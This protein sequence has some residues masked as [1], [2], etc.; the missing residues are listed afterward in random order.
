MVLGDLISVVTNTPSH[1]RK[2]EASHLWVHKDGTPVKELPK[3]RAT[4]YVGVTVTALDRL[5]IDY[6]YYVIQYLQ[7]Q[8]AF[9]VQMNETVSNTK[10]VLLNVKLSE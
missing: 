10:K 7:M 3:E 6:L 2:W 9:A 4:N 1:K 8:K 5:N